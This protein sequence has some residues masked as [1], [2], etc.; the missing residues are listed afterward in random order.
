MHH[1][2]SVPKPTMELLKQQN[3]ELRR[4]QMWHVEATA[5][6]SH[7]GRWQSSAHQDVAD[8]H[9]NIAWSRNCMFLWKL[10]GWRQT[11]NKTKCFQTSCNKSSMHQKYVARLGLLLW[12]LSATL[13]HKSCEGAE[14]HLDWPFG[15]G[16]E[17]GQPSCGN[18][19]RWW[20]GACSPQ[21]GLA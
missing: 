4:A 3:C 10:F 15:S 9:T 1:H 11:M 16:P 19:A 7:N 14:Q 6:L 18:A 8:L 12:C 17:S 2:M 13:Q 5:G 21:L 20:L